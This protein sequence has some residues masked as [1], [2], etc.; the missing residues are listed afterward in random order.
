MRRQGATMTDHMVAL[1]CGVA[2]VGVYLMPSQSGAS[3]ATYALAVTVLVSG[4]DRWRAF[5]QQRLLAG[6]F[7]ALLGYFASSVWWSSEWS[8]RGAF[9]IYSRSVLILTFVVALSASLARFPSV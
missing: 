9:S 1:L 6:L 5:A 3:F 7:V 8:M 2:L 4:R